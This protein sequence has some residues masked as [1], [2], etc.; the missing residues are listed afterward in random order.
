MNDVEFYLYD[1]KSKFLKINPNEYY[2]AYSGGKV[3]WDLEDYVIIAQAFARACRE[4]NVPI[5]WGGA[6][7][8]TLNEMDASEAND[9]YISLRKSQQRKV[10]IDG[11]HFEIPKE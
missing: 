6:W 7:H 2:L 5:R 8:T 4:L 10:F 3:S 1:L 9:S 11:P